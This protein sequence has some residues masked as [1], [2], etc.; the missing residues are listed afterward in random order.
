MNQNWFS[1]FCK[2]EDSNGSTKSRL[3]DWCTIGKVGAA[4]AGG[5]FAVAGAPVVLSAAGFTA[6]GKCL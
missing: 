2:G 4:V 6:G 5:A 1:V 3:P